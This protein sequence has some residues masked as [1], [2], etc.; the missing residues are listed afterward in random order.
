MVIDF[1]HHARNGFFKVKDFSVCL[2]PLFWF[3]LFRRWPSII[4][5]LPGRQSQ[6]DLATTS[7]YLFSR[8]CLWCLWWCIL[9]ESL[10]FGIS[11]N[12]E[13]KR[14]GFKPG[15]L[16]GEIKIKYL[17]QT[18]QDLSVFQ[19]RCNPGYSVTPVLIW[20]QMNGSNPSHVWA[21]DFFAFEIF[22][23]S[24]NNQSFPSINRGWRIAF[25]SKCILWCFLVS[26]LTMR[27]RHF[28]PDT[29]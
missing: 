26:I 9:V 24:V 28:N 13:F 8:H 18:I 3:H 23:P 19:C 16:Y 4:L 7:L 11:K 25:P 17:S 27:L 12:D 1:P 15:S 22:T 21:A 20:A 29:A 14:T 6:R 10:K 2:R 5:A